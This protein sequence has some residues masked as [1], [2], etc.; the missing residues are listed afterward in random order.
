VP[1]PLSVYE[2]F[3]YYASILE[4]EIITSATAPR[5]TPRGEVHGCDG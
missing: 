1:A 5:S 4:L 2:S 3:R